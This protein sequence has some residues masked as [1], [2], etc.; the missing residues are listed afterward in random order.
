MG[1]GH[2]HSHDDV[3]TSAG[4]LPKALDL[5]VPE[6][7]LSPGDATRRRFLLGAGLLGAGAAAS[8][9]ARPGAAE[10]AGLP[11]THG[12]WAG[13]S[14]K[15][16]FRWLAGDH[17]IHTQYSSDAQY[18]VL[19]QAQKGQAYGLD[20][21]VI[22]DHGSAAHAKI[23]VEKV[24]PDIVK[25]REELKG[26][27][28]FQGLE[29]NI[30]A[31]EHATVFVTP[32]RNEVEVLKQFEN[33]YDGTFVPSTNTAAQNEALAIA[34]IKFLGEQV[35]KRKIDGALFFANHPAR[36]GIDSP[37]EIRGWRDADPTVAVG[38]E[39][40]PGHQAAG[41]PAPNGRGGARGYYDNNPSAASFPGYPLESYRTWGGFDWMTATVGGLWDSLLAEGKA[42]WITVN[43][44]SHVNYL[45]Q[46]ERGPG[47]DFNAN[48]KY[49]DPVYNG[50]VNTQAGDFWPGF[51]GRTNVGASSF[52]YKAVV[53]G[54]RAGRV[55][56]D[57]GRLVKGLDARVR[58]SGDRRLSHGTP[59]GGVLQVRRGTATE[60]T[61]DIDLQDIPNWAGFIPA[62]KRVDVIVG[63]VTGPVA[64]RDAFTTPNTRVV[65][66][67]EISRT[68]GR[69]TLTY[70]LGRLDKPFYLRVRG[71]DGN[72]TQPGL[73][74]ASVDPYGPQLD[75]SGAADPWGDL[76][77]YTNPIWVLPR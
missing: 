30:P 26:L 16:G 38:F 36:R 42:W 22:T 77:F 65:K 35:K 58:V 27:L 54:L 61:L 11:H 33:A 7:E 72:R 13:G 24:N 19:D 21:L 10:A 73:M 59:L 17:H 51:Y 47:S 5:S 60:L 45:D 43:S 71:T 4:D 55:W 3:H 31:A 70:P 48:G 37:H 25:T 32:S 2:D 39:G 28:T 20:W 68:S 56:V 64:D 29:W 67:F 14:D 46:T 44:D 75:V 74:G 63:T 69:I 34:G 18:R 40:A 52:S 41:I 15:G 62:L 8:V 23:G 57:H 6:S 12:S 66:S 9:L 76:W 1:H 53:D 49:N 50:S